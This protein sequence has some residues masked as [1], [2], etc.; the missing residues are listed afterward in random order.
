MM[1][2]AK[3]WTHHDLQMIRKSVSACLPRHWQLGRWLWNTWPQGHMRT[4][5]VIMLHP[6][7][8]QTSEVV[9]GERDHEVQALPPQRA[10]EPLTQ[11][12]RLGTV[13]WGLEDT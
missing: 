11:G 10:Q 7:L 9:L 6:L 1:Q 5:S 2:A 12:I 3:D 8:E 13:H 4:A